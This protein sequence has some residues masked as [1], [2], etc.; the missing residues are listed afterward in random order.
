[1]KVHAY[2]APKPGAALAPVEIDVPAPSP[3]EVTIA[4][5]HCGICHSDIHLIDDDWGMSSFPLV[6]GH[7]VVGTVTALGSGVRHL[8]EGQRVGVGW[9]CGSCGECE[10][11]RRGEEELCAAAKATC[12]NQPGGYAT[13]V[14][15]Q[16]RFAVPLPV[17]LD[18]A[19]A[20]PLLCGGVTVYTPLRRHARPD[21]KV[22]VIGIGGLGHLALQLAA[23]MGCEVTAY[24]TSPNKEAEARLLG[25]HRFVATGAEDALK[26]ESVTQDLLISAVTADLDWPAWI[27]VVRPRGT[28][29][30]VGASPNEVHVHPFSLIVGDRS[31]AGSQIGSPAFIGE[32]LGLAARAGVKAAAE[33]FPMAEVNAALERVRANQVRYRAVLVS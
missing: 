27:N 2:A 25:A 6:P 14:N 26:A 22:G 23:A 31:I 19:T 20:A 8:K 11:C 24:S 30:L 16:A 9:Q 13:H 4:V 17:G 21:M 29:C 3:G 28:L 33:L 7:E 18:A 15:A 32:M 1:M 12:V 10:W 5:S